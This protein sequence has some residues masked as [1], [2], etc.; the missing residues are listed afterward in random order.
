MMIYKAEAGK[1]ANTKLN[2]FIYICTTSLPT[3]SC[4]QVLVKAPIFISAEDWPFSCTKI[5]KCDK[6]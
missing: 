1:V 2:I 3:T 5:A 4:F 6:P